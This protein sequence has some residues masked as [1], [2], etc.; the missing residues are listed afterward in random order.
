M[1]DL[2]TLTNRIRFVLTCAPEAKAVEEPAGRFQIRDRDMRLSDTHD[3]AA[4]AWLDAS[5]RG[6][7]VPAG[8][9]KARVRAVHP[10]AVAVPCEV[11]E[12]RSAKVRSWFI[13]DAYDLDDMPALGPKA[14]TE[15][16][17]WALA[18]ARL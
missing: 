4:D 2:N 6:T 1:H 15:Q 18:V 10:T 3:T 5:S 12:S 13:V 16:G 9:H 7:L 17:A 14:P 11:A 8:L